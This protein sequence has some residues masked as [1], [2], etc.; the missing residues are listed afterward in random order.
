[1][2]SNKHIDSIYRSE[3]H[4]MGRSLTN[5]VAI[6]PKAKGAR[7]LTEARKLAFG[8]KPKQYR[9]CRGGCYQCGGHG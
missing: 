5:Y 1:M 9:C 7:T 3:W 8:N 4:W 6:H 2:I